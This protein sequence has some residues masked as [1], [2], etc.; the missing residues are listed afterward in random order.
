[1]EHFGPWGTYV[2]LHAVG[3][4]VSGPCPVPREDLGPVQHSSHWPCLLPYL[5][6]LLTGLPGQTPDLVHHH[7]MSGAVNRACYHHSSSDALFRPWAQLGY[8]WLLV[9]PCNRR[10]PAPVAHSLAA[11]ALNSAGPAPRPNSDKNHGFGKPRHLSQF[12]T[13]SVYHRQQMHTR[14]AKAPHLR[15]EKPE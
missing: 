7:P 14:T 11:A 15:G 12:P 2:W 13:Y 8:L 5:L 3:E 10:S 6:R 1:M 4:H 9:H